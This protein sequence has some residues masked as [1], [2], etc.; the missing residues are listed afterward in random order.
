MKQAT[1]CKPFTQ[2]TYKEKYDTE[3]SPARAAV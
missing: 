3:M 1:R 2:A